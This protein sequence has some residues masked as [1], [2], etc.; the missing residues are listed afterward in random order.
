MWVSDIAV[1]TSQRGQWAPLGALAGA[2]AVVTDGVGV[3]RIAGGVAAT[4]LAGPAGALVAL[5]KKR[6]AAALV[7]LA[8]GTVHQHE[9]NGNAAVRESLAAIV[10]WSNAL[11]ANAQEPPTYEQEEEEEEEEEE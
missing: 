5:S 10:S 9:L 7:V 11:A 8:D 2:E 3:H 1:V 6:Q 4:V